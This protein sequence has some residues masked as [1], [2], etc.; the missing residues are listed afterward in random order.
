[1]RRHTHFFVTPPFFKGVVSFEICFLITGIRSCVFAF[2]VLKRATKTKSHPPGSPGPTERYASRM[3]RRAR[4]RFT[5]FPIFLL[6]VI[7][8]RLN[9]NRF[10]RACVTSSGCGQ[11]FP[12]AYNRLK[13]LFSL[14][15]TIFRFIDCL[16][17]FQKEKTTTR[18]GQRLIRQMLSAFCSAAR[19]NLAS[20]LRRHSLAEAVLLFSLAFLRL[21]SS[22]HYGTLLFHLPA[23]KPRDS[24]IIFIL[25]P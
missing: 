7:P 12:L 5:A 1:M 8:T 3:I 9:G 24:G 10:F 15:V 6:V 21:V 11:D 14:S 4:F 13:S 18:C 17:C 22:K 16:G 2:D 23:R 19:Q 20:V 25:P